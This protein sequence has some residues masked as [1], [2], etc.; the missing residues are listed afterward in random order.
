MAK[1]YIVDGVSYN[2]PDNFDDSAA[3][4]ILMKQGIIRPGVPKPGLPPDL[5]KDPNA[6]EHPT[7]GLIG[8]G[9]RRM[10][11]GVEAMAQPGVDSKMRGASEIIRG[12]GTASIPAAIPLAA[13][14]IPAAATAIGGG[15]LG[16]KLGEEASK[17]SGA[18]PEG[19]NLASDVGGVVG[20]AV[21][22]QIGNSA[23]SRIKALYDAIKD[24]PQA[25]AAL[26]DLIPSFGSKINK[27]RQ[28]IDPT[29]VP[30]P[31]SSIPP[32]PQR[33]SDIMKA[34]SQGP[35]SKFPTNVPP[36]PQSQSNIMAMRSQ[37]PPPQAQT[38]PPAQYQSPAM[39]AKSTMPGPPTKVPPPPQYQS[40]AMAALG[41]PP[42]PTPP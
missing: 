20:G 28:A 4:T 11:G 1:T 12:A 14:N 18:S 15:Y 27:L 6:W 36:P 38:T 24:N 34:R 7:Y 33:Q 21:G 19:V 13:S 23:T 10:V 37:G 41:S 22:G 26:I 2:F 30:T 16:S 42:A 17:Y 5:Q 40:P 25:K 8:Q 3:Q 31:K 29:T 32:P 35:P 9:V 39:A